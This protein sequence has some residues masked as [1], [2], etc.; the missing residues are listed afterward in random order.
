MKARLKTDQ[1]AYK[2]KKGDTI[3]VFPIGLRE[4][5]SCPFSKQM[6]YRVQRMNQWLPEEDLEI[7]K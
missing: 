4:M 3:E 5:S 1:T 7:L 6:M 2:L